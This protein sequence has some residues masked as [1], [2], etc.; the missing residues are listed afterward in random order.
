MEVINTA[1][2]KKAVSSYDI[3]VTQTNGHSSIH[4]SFNLKELGEPKA[5]ED[6][7]TE[8]AKLNAELGFGGVDF[9]VRNS[10]FY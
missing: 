9:S 2:G 1:S 3:I 5:R 4:A 7:F 8:C 10:F 6:A